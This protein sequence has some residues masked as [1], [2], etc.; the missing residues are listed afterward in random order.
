MEGR[1]SAA[2]DQG[3]EQQVQSLEAGTSLALLKNGK[4]ICVSGVERG[5]RSER[6]RGHVTE[7]FM[8]PTQDLACLSRAM[9]TAGEQEGVY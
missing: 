6:G 4:E 7:G 9:E 2:A 5:L 8:V 1:A 3:R